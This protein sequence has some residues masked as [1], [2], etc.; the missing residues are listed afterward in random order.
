MPGR[1]P[2]FALDSLDATRAAGSNANV[3]T[4]E[5]LAS[6]RRAPFLVLSGISKTFGGTVALDRID[7]SVDRGEVHCLVGENGSGKSTLIKILAGVHTPDS[8]GSITIEETRY[9]NLTP[10]QAKRLGV[11]VI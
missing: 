11:Q 10:H 1:G 5:S 6:G 4:V 3:M 9:A 7:W 8:G 2:R